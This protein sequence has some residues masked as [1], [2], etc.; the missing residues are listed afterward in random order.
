MA[1]AIPEGSGWR[2]TTERPEF[3]GIYASTMIGLG[4]TDS[5]HTLPSPAAGECRRLTCDS[6]MPRRQTSQRT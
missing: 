5:L 2:P 6:S 4:P 1:K 3:S